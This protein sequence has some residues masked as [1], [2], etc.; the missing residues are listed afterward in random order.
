MLKT[1]VSKFNVTLQTRMWAFG[2]VTIQAASED[3]AKKK[4]LE[5]YWEE[6]VSFTATESDD[7][8]DPKIVGVDVL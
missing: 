2:T 5:K 3:E 8:Y 7:D 4:A 6:A 1:K